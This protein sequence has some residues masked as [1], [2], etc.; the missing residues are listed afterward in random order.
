MQRTEAL[1]GYAFVAPGVIGVTVFTAIPLIFAVVMSFTSWNMMSA[2]QFLGLQNYVELFGDAQVRREFLNTL[3]FAIGTAPIGVFL[4]LVLANL[5][6]TKIRG[7]SIYRT[8]FF[9]PYVSMPAAI[10]VTW[11][12]MLNS[13]HGL[14]NQ[15]CGWVGLPQLK[16]MTD[17]KLIMPV[18]I[19]ISIWSSLGYNMIILL[20]GLQNISATF[21]EAAE[22]DGATP[23]QKFFMITMPLISPTTFF[24]MIMS[25]IGSF[26][27]FDI[28]YM[29]IGAAS[30][31]GGPLSDATRTAVYGIY[32]RGLNFFR[33]GYA[34]S[35]A[36]VLFLIILLVT[37]F[38]FWLQKKWVYYE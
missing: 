1:W 8:I 29:L 33:M 13:E 23:F 6:N 2:P 34:S 36:V 37:G 3:Y 9:L 38:Q 30:A 31:A 4:S 21:Y 16:W 22:I 15:L 7:L 17:P 19:F 26:K 18:I 27:A 25:F 24:L 5:L 14:V 12:W 28:V 20:A 32:E 11:K 10:T 35:E